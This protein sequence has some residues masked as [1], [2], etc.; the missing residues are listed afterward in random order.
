M[1]TNQLVPAWM[2]V[3]NVPVQDKSL[4]ASFT[5]DA[6]TIEFEDNIGIQATWTGTPTGTFS[7]EVS[8]DPSNLGWQA[9]TFTPAPTQPTGSTGTIYFPVNQTPA[10]FIRL[11]YT[12]VSGTGTINAKISAKSV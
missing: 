8:L 11:V 7:V 6:V 10:G 1:S 2:L 9:L 4:A 12:R 5:T 3:S